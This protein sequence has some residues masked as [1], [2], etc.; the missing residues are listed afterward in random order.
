MNYI[1]SPHLRQDCYDSLPTQIVVYVGAAALGYELLLIDHQMTAVLYS[2]RL[3]QSW[4]FCAFK[5]NVLV[6]RWQKKQ[7][8]PSKYGSQLNLTKISL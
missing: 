4:L 8:I 3:Q 5:N 6:S 1:K 2:C 7:L